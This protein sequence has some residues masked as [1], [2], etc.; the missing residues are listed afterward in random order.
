MALWF[1]TN[2]GSLARGPKA[3]PWDVDD[4]LTGFS[5]FRPEPKTHVPCKA[6]AGGPLDT[7]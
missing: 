4:V 2:I 3:A 1:T 7:M 5:S 6:T